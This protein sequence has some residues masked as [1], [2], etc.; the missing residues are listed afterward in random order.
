MSQ[1]YLSFLSQAINDLL[2]TK[3][4][5]IENTGLDIFRGLAVILIVWFGVKSA[6]SAAQGH[7][8][9]FHFAKFDT[10]NPEPTTR[11]G[12]ARSRATPAR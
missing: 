1:N 4:A 12:R 6:L 9:G 11:T 8:G 5:A 2:T 3:S 10:G 7:G